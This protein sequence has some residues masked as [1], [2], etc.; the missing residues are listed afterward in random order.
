MKAV[1]KQRT[2]AKLGTQRGEAE[3]EEVGEE[4]PVKQRRRRRPAKSTGLPG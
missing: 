3:M 4:R 2:F 1:R